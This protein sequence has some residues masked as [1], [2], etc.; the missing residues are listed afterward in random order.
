MF[1]FTT[2]ANLT[3]AHAAE[4][5]IRIRTWFQF[6]LNAAVTLHPSNLLLFDPLLRQPYAVAIVQ[7]ERIGNTSLPSI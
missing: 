4:E 6:L 7:I 5:N 2:G 3:P 1:S